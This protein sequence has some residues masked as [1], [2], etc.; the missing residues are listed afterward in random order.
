MTFEAFVAALKTLSSIPG[1]QHANI[2]N[3]A[4]NLSPTDRTVFLEM[5][6]KLN[7]AVA[8]LMSELDAAVRNMEKASADC[9][10]RLQKIDREESES[11]QHT[12]ELEE[13]ETLLTSV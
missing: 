4:R 2:T 1:E 13:A 9:V 6:T 7:T 8:T 11:G 10:T 5:F 3:A 12:A